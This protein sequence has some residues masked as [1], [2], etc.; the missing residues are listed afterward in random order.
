MY[1]ADLILPLDFLA[2]DNCAS[3]ILENT[4]I[5]IIQ[6]EMKQ[7]KF[8]QDYHKII[9]FNK[10]KYRGSCPKILTVFRLGLLTTFK[11]FSLIF[12]KL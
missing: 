6:S 7:K 12:T 5:F 10:V 4:F 8:K 9:K 3:M 1:Y 11:R 2:T